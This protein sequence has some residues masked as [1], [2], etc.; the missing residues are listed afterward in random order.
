MPLI[1]ES[2][3]TGEIRPPRKT[4]LNCHECNHE[5]KYRFLGFRNVLLFFQAFL[6]HRDGCDLMDTAILLVALSRHGN[7]PRHTAKDWGEIW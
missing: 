3:K 2:A 7:M 1:I 6:V 5:I 4:E